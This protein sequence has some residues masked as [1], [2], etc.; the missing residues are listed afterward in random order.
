MKFCTNCG[1]RI[2]DG[3]DACPACGKTVAAPGSQEAPRAEQQPPFDPAVSQQQPPVNPAPQPN[4]NYQN[5]QNYQNPYGAQNTYYYPPQTPA[6]AVIVQ[7]GVAQEPVSIG[8]YILMSL[9]SGLPM[10]G[11]ITMIVIA[12]T[13]ENKSKKNYCIAHLIIIAIVFVLTLLFTL[14]FSGLILSHLDELQNA[15]R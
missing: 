11:L 8:W 10:I 7:N 9:V 14:L 1:T 6:P 3:A 5:Y 13:A 4:S 12:C 2:P 15:F